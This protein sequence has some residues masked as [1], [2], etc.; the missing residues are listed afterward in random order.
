MILFSTTAG[1]KSMRELWMT[2]PDSLMPYIDQNHRTEMVEFLGMNLRGDVDNLFG[3]KSEMDTITA[4]YASLTLN[5][6][7]E[8]QLKKL[9][10][11]AD[12]I[13]CMLRTVKGPAQESELLFFSQDWKPLTCPSPLDK[14]TIAATANQ[15]TYKPD[16]MSQT[17]FNELKALLFPLIIRGKLSPNEDELELQ[18]SLPVSPSEERDDLKNITP[19][20]YWT[21]KSGKFLPKS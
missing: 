7:V 11:G 2:I 14:V 5:E 19:K 1:A 21:W 16:T 13:V 15:L 3:G 4:N 8:V 9:P 10:V 12:S 6:A 20:K 18:I 17:R